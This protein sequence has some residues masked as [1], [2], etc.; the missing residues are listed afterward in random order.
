MH[1]MSAWN[2]PALRLPPSVFGN[3]SGGV[4][5]KNPLR[6]KDVT[7]SIEVKS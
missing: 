3:G 7:A 2:L 4:N 1:L 6:D 5:W